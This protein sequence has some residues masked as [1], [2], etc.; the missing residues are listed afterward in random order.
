MIYNSLYDSVLIEVDGVYN[1]KTTIKNE[2]GEKIE[3]QLD[4]RSHENTTEAAKRRVLGRVVSVCR[5]ISKN[6]NNMAYATINGFPTAVKTYSYTQYAEDNGYPGGRE[7]TGGVY[8]DE[9]AFNTEIQIKEN[10]V[11]HFHYLS[12]NKNSLVSEENGKEIHRIDYNNIFAFIRDNKIHVING[13]VLAS[14]E[15]VEDVQEIEYEGIKT[16]MEVSKS[17]IIIDHKPDKKK[18][19]AIVTHVGNDVGFEKRD[20]RLGDNIFF[21]IHKNKIHTIN[22]KEFY[23]IKKQNLMGCKRNGSYVPYGNYIMTVPIKRKEGSVILS[24][25]YKKE[26]VR[27]RV[28]KTGEQV[29]NTYEIGELVHFMPKSNAMRYIEEDNVL[30]IKEDY[31]YMVSENEVEVVVKR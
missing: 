6:I 17:G 8:E 14:P 7:Y 2:K 30:F 28:I 24:E 25:G 27:G 3:L 23:A 20:V 21:G 12:L 22:G 15:Y 10:D 29:E 9:F 26:I 16:K 11:I 5:K 1:D 31:C 4:T 18:Q 19:E 13:W